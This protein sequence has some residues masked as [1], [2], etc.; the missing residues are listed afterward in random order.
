MSV[1]ARR[2]IVRGRVQGVNYRG[3][4]RERAGDTV[5]GYAENR[6]DGSVEVWVQGAP[7]DV[8][9]VERAVRAGP[10]HA[11]VDAVEADDVS[12]R[13]HLDGFARR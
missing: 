12:P 13:E 4:V 8:A 5:A 7:G 9:R 6:E 11:R 3:W 1:V 2:L 10:A